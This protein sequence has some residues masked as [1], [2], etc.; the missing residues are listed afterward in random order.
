ML[1]GRHMASQITGNS[2]KYSS[3]C[4]SLQGQQQQTL[5]W[6][7]SGCNSLSN[8][9]PHDCIL[10]RLFRRRSKKTSKP[11]VTGLCAHKWPV[12]RKMFPFDDV[13]MASHHWLNETKRHQWPVDSRTNRQ[14]R[15]R[16]CSTLAHVTACFLTAP[17]HYQNQRWLIISNVQWHS[18]ESNYTHEILR[19]SITKLA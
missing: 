7:H 3:L 12:T 5:Q 1:H 15:Q 13:I 6:R 8:H 10:N 11:R 18:S 16:K 19:S 4:S 9:Q 14:N 17:S 2:E